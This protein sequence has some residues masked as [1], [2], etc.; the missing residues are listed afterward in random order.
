MDFFLSSKCLEQIKK[1]GIGDNFEIK[2]FDQSVHCNIF[3]AL[4]I[5]NEIT[6]LYRSD[7][8]VY[9]F[10]MKFPPSSAFYD[11]ISGLRQMISRTNFVTIFSKLLEGQPIH[12]NQ[13]LNDN[14]SEDMAKL[15][16]EF[17]KMLGNSEMIDKGLKLLKIGINEE[18]NDIESVIKSIKIKQKIKLGHISAQQYNIISSNFYS[19]FKDEGK[20]KIKNDLISILKNMNQ[21]ELE[22]I[23]ASNNLQIE[24][25][26]SFFD[27]ILSLGKDF[28][29]LFDF[30]EVQFL[31]V[32][33]VQKL[34]D[35]IQNYELPFHRRL[36]SSICRR[37]LFDIS[38]INGNKNNRAKSTV[39]PKQKPNV[40]QAID[41]ENGIFKFLQSSSNDN[42]YVS[43]AI[44]VT[45]SSINSGSI[46]NLF[47]Q[48]K[49]TAIKVKDDKN[50]FIIIDFKD[51]KVNVKNYYLSVPAIKYSGSRPKTW[52]VDGSNDEQNWEMIDSQQNNSQLT[53]YGAF[54]TFA[55]KNH[56]ENYYRYIRIKEIISQDKSHM[57]L[58]SEIELF[59][60]IILE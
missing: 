2:I 32:E 54:S 50:S 57:M 1:A 25:E 60:S 30:V 31:S 11:N 28:Y 19:I 34:I 44:D 4:L 5:S 9:Q 53:N 17:G 43:G 38:V 40:N 56:N 26:D 10:N 23:F 21:N 35:N 12:F 58:L 48:S 41:C 37:L 45:T 7:R 39:K 29:F 36:W 47:D 14:I 52:I 49:N 42:V 3:V 8:T 20:G 16:V 18:S 55:C 15:T 6:K 51:K 27:F 46:E 33:K 24:T 13:N 22:C 59:G